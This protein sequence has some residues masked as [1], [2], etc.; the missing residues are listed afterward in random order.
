MSHLAGA[1]YFDRRTILPHHYAE[2][3]EVLGT[4]GPHSDRAPIAPGLVMMAHGHQSLAVSGHHACTWH[5]RLDNRDDVTSRL[6][7]AVPVDCGVAELALAT[8]EAEGLEGFR[9]LIGDWSLAIWDA[10]T[11]TIVLASDYAGIQPLYYY[12]QPHRI[13]WASS[14]AALRT[15]ARVDELDDQYVAD[16]LTRGLTPRRTPYRDIQPVPAGGFVRVVEGRAATGAFWDLP[17]GKTLHYAHEGEYEEQLTALFRESVRARLRTTAPSCAELSGGLDSSSVVCMANELISAGTVA[18]PKLLTFSYS[19]KGS[20]DEKFFRAVERFCNLSGQHLELSA[21]PLIDT[22]CVGGGAPMFWGARFTE[23]RRRMASWSSDVLLTGQLG[24]LIMG[25]WLDDSEQVADYVARGKMAGAVREAFSWSQALRAP[26]YPILWRALRANFHR[27]HPSE[28]SDLRVGALS[29]DSLRASFRK[30]MA[31]AAP[32][33]S[34]P[35]WRDVSPGRRKHFWAVA[36]TLEARQLQCPELLQDVS[37]SHP[38][39]HRPLVEF[40]LTIP[41]AI[42][43]RPGE[44]RRLMRRAFAGLLPEVVL[45]RRSKASYDGAFVQALRPPANHLLQTLDKM[46]LVERGYVD[47]ESIRIRLGR[48]LQGLDC[49]GAQLRRLILLEYWIRH[50]HRHPY[51]APTD[52]PARLVSAPLH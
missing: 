31:L 13:V 24:D 28:N 38:F 19:Q 43:C 34:R 42:V 16:F 52:A 2:V 3:R 9:N 44:P 50:E 29:G 47:R 45:K 8:Y 40:M 12:R 11:R 21:H 6:G 5:G 10:R 48:L 37:Y 26:V 35:S 20:P 36:E 39:A 17:I 30:R 32:P 1:F 14:L 15:W 7:S 33:Q 27:G 49:N 4:L 22:T 23:V 46:C 41:A 25:N 18:S 51:L